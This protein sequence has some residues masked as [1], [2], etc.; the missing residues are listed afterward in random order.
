MKISAP[1]TKTITFKGK[2]WCR[3]KIVIDGKIYVVGGE[4]DVQNKL[5]RFLKMSG[6][7]NTVERLGRIKY[8]E[9]LA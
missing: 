5:N 3:S 2:D 7:M 9:K 6:S 4:V 8:H 1:K